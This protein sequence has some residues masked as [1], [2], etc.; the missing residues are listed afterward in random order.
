MQPF[1]QCETKYENASDIVQNK[2]QLSVNDGA[3]DLGA[4]EYHI[5]AI[6]LALVVIISGAGKWSIDRLLTGRLEVHRVTTN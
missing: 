6:G 4:C 3:I 5:L 2:R 1:T